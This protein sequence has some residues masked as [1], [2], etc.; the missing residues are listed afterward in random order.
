MEFPAAVNPRFPGQGSSSQGESE[1][2]S[3]PEGV[4]DG[5]RVNIPAP[6]Q[7]KYSGDVRWE[8]SRR[9]KVAAP[10]KGGTWRLRPKWIILAK[11]QEKPLCVPGLSVPQ[12]DTGG[13][14]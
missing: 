13:W 10:L 1:P 14:A 2:K 8:Y 3:R 6:V 12:T 11:Y 4:D 5:E 9:L 7:L